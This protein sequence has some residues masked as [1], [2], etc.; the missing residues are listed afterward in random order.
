MDRLGRVALM[1]MCTTALE[2]C[3]FPIIADRSLLF[4][5]WHNCIKRPVVVGRRGLW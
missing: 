2:Q 5:Q 1:D 3:P 4:Q